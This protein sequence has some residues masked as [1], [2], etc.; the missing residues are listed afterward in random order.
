MSDTALPPFHIAYSE[1]AS[2]LLAALGCSL[3]ISTYQAGKVIF[4]SA[5]GNG[6]LVQLPRS[7]VRAMGIAVKDD[8]MAVACRDEV[9]L[10]KNSP[11][12]A[13]H[14]PKK[15]KCYDGMYLPRVTYHTGEVDVHDID[16]VEGGLAAVNTNFSC[17]IKIDENFSFTPI[18]KPDFI[19]KITAGDRCHL[20][21]M[22]VDAQGAIRFVSAF[23]TT[24]VSRGWTKD[25]M[26]TGVVIDYKTQD[27]L[28]SGL[29]MPHSPRLVGD[30]LYLLQSGTGELIRIHAK[31]GAKETVYKSEGFVRGLAIHKD[32]AFVGLSKVRKESSSFGQLDIAK[33]AVQ[34]GILIINLKSGQLEGQIM[35]Q[36]SVDEIY[37]V[38]V[39]PQLL[40][41]SILNT[42]NDNHKKGLSLPETTF[43]GSL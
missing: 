9:I 22:A 10:L 35:Y 11:Q 3:A 1:S 36:Q 17:I 42:M 29:V 34:A 19:S 6:R 28:A 37:D 5:Q 12:L 2:S 14:Y 38:Q 23:A 26:Q 15:P 7:F 39:L 41:P 4:I 43:W 16:F 21:G 32:Y 31:T 24:D 30:F 33:T 25:L 13:W 8:M 27:I 18:W 40:R 20:N